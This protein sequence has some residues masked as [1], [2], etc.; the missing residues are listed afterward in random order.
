MVVRRTVLVLVAVLAAALPSVPAAQ[1]APPENAQRQHTVASYNLFL[2]GDI[3]SLTRATSAQDFVIRAAALWRNVGET[4]FPE[5]ADA[6]A[7][8]LAA[9]HPDV[10]GLQEVAKWETGPPSGGQ[11]VPTYDFLALLLDALA[12]RGTPYRVLVTNTNFVSPEVPLVPLAPLRVK[13]TDR[14]VVI[15]RADLPAAQLK[16]SNPSPHIFQARIPITLPVGTTEIIRGWSTVDV[17]LRGKTYRFA[18]THLE[19][20]DPTVRRLQGAELTQSLAASPHPVVLVGDLNSRPDDMLGPYGQAKAIGLVDSW[21]TAPGTGDGDTSGQTDSLRNDPS[22]IDHRIDYVLYQP[23][24]TP[25][26]DAVEA[27]VIGE[28]DADRTVTGMWPSDHAGVVA[29]L[30]VGHP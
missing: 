21:L 10:V 6:I 14:D 9:D 15:A 24:G 29:T 30:H 8:L 18:N 26:L 23:D 5:R 3:G 12:D 27:H 11:L 16:A 22:T 1:A 2:G 17:K 28:E 7:D 25:S 4:N 20:F 19:A 13:F